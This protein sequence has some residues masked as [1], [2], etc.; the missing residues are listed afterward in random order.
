MLKHLFIFLVLS[1]LTIGQMIAQNRT[2]KGKV[3]DAD[4]N[5][6]IPGVSVSVKGTTSGTT[7]D[8][9]GNF[10]LA[11]SEGAVLIFQGVGL[12]LQEVTVGSQSTVAV[13]M[14]SESKQLGEVVVVGYG[15]I[16][17]RKDLTG[18]VATVKGSDVANLPVQSFEQAL[19]GRMA[20]VN[21]T[22]PNGVLGN[23]PVIRVRGTNSITSGAQPLIVIDGLPIFSGQASS[24]TFTSSNALADINPN[25]IESY[26]VLKD[27]SAS[28][29]Y[30]SRAANG[31]L[32]ITT[33]KGQKGKAKVQYSSW[34]GYTE[35]FRKFSVLNAQQFMT[36]KNEAAANNPAAAGGTVIANPTFNADG[37]VVDTDWYSTV[38]QTG[39]QQNHHLNVSGGDER[40]KY[41]FGVGYTDQNGMLV[42]NRFRRFTGRFNI[43]HQVTNYLSVGANIQMTNSFTQS[44]NT[45]STGAFSIGGLGRLPLVLPPNVSPRLPNGDYNIEGGNRIG[46]GNNTQP[47]GSFYNPLVDQELSK[48]TS[49]NNTLVGNIYAELKLL[50]GLTMRTTAGINSVGTED[51][52]F[53]NPLHGEGQTLNGLASNVYSRAT[54]WNWQNTIN[55]N[56]TFADKHTID[57]L[58]GAEYQQTK[59]NTW[60]GSRQNINDPFLTSYQGAFQTNNPPPVFQT[61]NALESY[62]LR[63]NYSY[64]GKYLFTANLRRDGYSALS[65]NNKFGNFGGVS[66]GWRISDENFIKNTTALSFIDDFKVRASW[67]RLGNVNIGDFSSLNLFNAGLYGTVPTW[68]FSQVG[69]ADLK[70][71]SSTKT[72]IGFDASFF[73]GKVQAS[74]SY[75]MNNIDNL[76]IGNPLPPSMGIPGSVIAQNV[77]SMENKGIELT[78][79]TTNIKKGDFE[80]TTDFNFTTNRNKVLSLNERGSDI[81][82]VTGGLESTNI[83]R[84][85]EPVGSLFAVRSAGVNPVNGRAMFINAAGRTVQYSHATTPRWSFVDDGSAASSPAGDRVLAGNTNPTWFG[86]IG[87]T[88]R[89]KG[90]DFNIFFQFSGGNYIY[91]GTRAGLLDQ[92]MWNNSTDILA[93]W[94]TPGQNTDIPRVVFNDNISNGSAFPLTKN[95]E[96]GDFLRVRNITLGYTLPTSILKKT[97]VERIRLYAQV[98][99][100]LVFTNYRGSD[101]E[102][103]TN[104]GS[105]ITPGVDR[106]ST[107]QSRTYSFGINVNF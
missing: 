15:G 43:S 54:T 25:D 42:K 37:S 52:D 70:W 2:V 59:F 10:E 71:E 88:L 92:R 28:A 80:W 106:N 64:M 23:P 49:E 100:A 33:R 82:G 8:V 1:L 56:H 24:G 101:P 97:G 39:F 65:K 55:Y 84:V 19:Q 93:R 91:N 73:K 26:E 78:I 72:D 44:P 104:G 38:Y 85:G 103:S 86:G 61:E 99:N 47:S 107:P 7:T 69:N 96:K 89:Y 66:V 90:I 9:E 94:T 30:G 83:T 41:Y 36:M 53:R 63:S 20:G 27:A 95:V 17:D 77:G 13:S 62:F 40:T 102:V 81:V 21:I 79:T 75:Y 98:Q 34:V 6:G 60:G 58:V 16:Q 4:T 46:S 48:F 14:K 67:G 50:K 74:F 87:N 105:N 51:I 68:F 29:I 12:A 22:T 31:V 5:E 32:L 76:I 45:G 3:T 57:L 11:V 18:V 35:A